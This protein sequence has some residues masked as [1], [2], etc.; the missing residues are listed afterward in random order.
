HFAGRRPALPRRFIPLREEPGA[1]GVDLGDL[2]LNRAQSVPPLGGDGVPILLVPLLQLTFL[3]GMFLLRTFCIG[4]VPNLNRAPLLPVA[5]HRLGPL[6]DAPLFQI[7]AQAAMP[8][9]GI[10]QDMAA[11]LLEFVP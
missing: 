10:A 6:A 1:L 11:P 3:A 9:S 7:C 2:V 4:V 8:V 5:C